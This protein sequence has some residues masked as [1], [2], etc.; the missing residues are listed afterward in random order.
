[1]G[2]TGRFGKSSSFLFRSN[3]KKKILFLRIRSTYLILYFAFS[4]REYGLFGNIRW[5]H[6]CAGI[7]SGHFIA[8]CHI[9]VNFM[10]KRTILHS[11]KTTST[12]TTATAATTASTYSNDHEL[13]LTPRIQS[14]WP[15]LKYFKL[16]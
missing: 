5:C 2:T 15:T 9:F 13:S 1:M 7:L 11:A 10:V 8:F 4:I 14:R 3:C 12:T 6:V 16:N